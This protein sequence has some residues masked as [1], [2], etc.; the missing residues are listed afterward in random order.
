MR[1]GHNTIFFGNQILN[2]QVMSRVRNLR[3]TLVTKFLN[4]RLQLF[5]N[6]LFEA[7]WVA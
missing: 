1:N 6:D 7:I 5:S 2:G 4:D 3:A